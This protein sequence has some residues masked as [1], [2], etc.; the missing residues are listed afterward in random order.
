MVQGKYGSVSYKNEN[1]PIP[2]EQWI[3]VEGTHE[4]IIDMDLWNT[5]QEMIKQK[6]K[7]FF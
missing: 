3:R 5:V 1:K 2:K 7:P 6:A 4:P